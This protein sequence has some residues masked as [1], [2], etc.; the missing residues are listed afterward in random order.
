M[1]VINRED[2]GFP[3]ESQISFNSE[4]QRSLCQFP[5]AK[6]KLEKELCHRGEIP[7]GFIW[8]GEECPECSPSTGKRVHQ[9]PVFFTA[10]KHHTGTFQ[11]C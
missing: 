8:V 1:N 5:V 4:S 6:K 9:A 2:W 11:M 10:Q 3:G 7:P